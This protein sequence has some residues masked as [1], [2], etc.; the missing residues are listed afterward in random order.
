MLG[1]VLG[2]A[3]THNINT[4]HNAMSEPPIWITVVAFL[5]AATVAAVTIAR[6]RKGYLLPIVLGLIGVVT[7]GLLGGVVLWIRHIGGLV[8]WDPAVYYFSTIPNEVDWPSAT[9]TLIG[10][11]I[12]CLL[13]A[14]IP[15]AKA[16]DTDPVEALR[17]E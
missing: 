6:G 8:V 2:W 17:H 12:F 5:L 1:L 15:A 9:V 14:V 7:F 16:A 10:A 13:G 3:I 4:I 11:V